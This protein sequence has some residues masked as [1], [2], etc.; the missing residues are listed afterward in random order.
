[1]TS[2]TRRN[3]VARDRERMMP[4]IPSNSGAS[5]AQAGLLAHNMLP[6][7]RAGR[8]AL[9]GL[10]GLAL[11]TE[12]VLLLG[13]LRPLSFRRHQANPPDG[14]PMVTLLGRTRDGALDFAVPALLLIGLYAASVWLAN[15]TQ[16][17]LA[18]ALALGAS[19]LFAA[20]LVPMFPGGTQDIFHN[21][22]DGRLFWR[23]GE[24]PTLVPPAAYPEDAFFPHLF[25]YTDLT[26]A[27]GPLWYLLSGLP[28][29][30]AGDGLVA[31]LVA[32]KVLMSLF[33]VATAALVTGASAPLRPGPAVIV[34]WCPLLLWEFAGN[35]HN[36]SIMVF[37]A[38]AAVVAAW[39]G[40]W[41]W[42]F[43]L[44]ALSA[45]VKFTTVLLGPVLL[46][47]L[48]RR[49]MPWRTL[50]LSLGLAA[51]LVVTTYLPFWAGRDTFRV[52]D[53]PG[54]TFILSPATLLQGTLGSW[55]ATDTAD[56]LTYGVTGAGFV[57][58][59]V[60]ALR[61][62][63]QEP[64]TPVPAAFDALFAY[65]LLASWWFWPWYLAWLAPLAALG[66]RF[67]RRR[68][69]FVLFAAAA[70]LSYCYWWD[71][72]PAHSR[73]WFELYTALTVGVFVVPA[74]LWAVVSAQPRSPTRSLGS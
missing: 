28:V 17:R 9:I 36:D 55:L 57:V 22:A 14:A 37:F 42:V 5:A 2:R 26:S 6:P 1:M 43:P 23:Y 8:L 48:S 54:M 19:L 11:A 46:V 29:T 13:W 12:L 58:L 24:N 52:L 21:V 45:L 25:G 10:A 65:L 41:V 16:G 67:D 72:P 60:L 47:W 69:V 27:Y 40:W 30:V 62:A 31:N 64:E 74:L 59:Y 68:W 49:G 34:G 44:L 4:R 32:Q 35:G 38:A 63:W 50:T 15:R 73:R 51:A 70:L 71:D 53:R 7:P 56:R 61:C 39:R 3:P 33:L 20:T 66:G 18:V